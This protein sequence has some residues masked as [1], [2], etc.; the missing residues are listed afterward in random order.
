MST[1]GIKDVTDI[2]HKQQEPQG[3]EKMRKCLAA[4]DKSTNPKKCICHKA[5]NEDSRHVL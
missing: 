2:A 1:T 4:A 5:G 3:G